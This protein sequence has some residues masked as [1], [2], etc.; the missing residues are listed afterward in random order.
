MQ[1]L[2]SNA[3]MDV[4]PMLY[5]EEPAPAGRRLTLSDHIERLQLRY[6]QLFDL[7]ILQS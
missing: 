3:D 5:V 2:I 1:F 4:D 6:N 7:V